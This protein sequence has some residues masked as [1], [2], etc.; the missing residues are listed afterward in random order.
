MNP[1]Q[2]FY[3]LDDG[4]HP[5]PR[6]FY[7]MLNKSLALPMLEGWASYLWQ[8]GRERNLIAL[9]DDREGQGYA[10]WRVMPASEAWQ[11]IVEHGLYAQ[12]IVF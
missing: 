3:L 2:P 7:A 5:I 11:S 12:T 4:A 6:L 9:L 1:G 10:A 8:K